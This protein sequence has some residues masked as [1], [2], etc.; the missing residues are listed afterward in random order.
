MTSKKKYLSDIFSDIPSVYKNIELIEAKVFKELGHLVVKVNGDNLNQKDLGEISSLFKIKFPSFNNVI[1]EIEKYTSSENLKTIKSMVEKHLNIDDLSYLVQKENGHYILKIYKSCDNKNLGALKSSLMD[2]SLDVHI[3]MTSCS[4]KN[5]DSFIEDIESADQAIAEKLS[6]N[7]IVE[8]KTSP[9]KKD[10]EN[11]TSE[12]FSY[13]KMPKKLPEKFLIKDLIPDSGKILVQGEIF[14]VDY[15]EIPAKALNIISIYFTDYSESTYTKVFIKD[16]DLNTYKSNLKEGSGISIVGEYTYDS[17]GKSDYIKASSFELFDIK[18][19]RDLANEKRIELHLH[20]SM[21]AQDGIDSP[22]E[23]IQR[24]SYW[25]HEAIA[26]TDHHNIQAFPEAMSSSKEFGIK[27]IYGLEVNLVDDT[28]DIIKNLSD[29]KYDSFVVFDVETTGFSSRNDKI[30]EIGAVKIENKKIVDSFNTL[31][32]P[33]RPISQEITDLTG[34]DDSMLIGQPKFEEICDEFANFI[35]GAILVAHNAAFDIGFLKTNLEKNGK[36]FDKAYI[37]TLEL[38]R[39]LYPNVRSHALGKIAK[40]LGISLENAHR[41]VDDARATA[42]VFM[43][44]T[45]D[46]LDENIE[47]SIT[48]IQAMKK[49]RPKYQGN[50][51]HAVLLAKNLV[52]LKN[53]YKIV[54]LS[55]MDYFYYTPRLPK[56]VLDE[57]RE[58]ILVSSACQDGEVFQNILMNEP[59]EKIKKTCSYYDYI[60]IQG[61]KNNKNLIPEY[62]NNKE[63]LENINKKIISFSDDLNIPVVATGDVHYLDEHSKKARKILSLATRSQRDEYDNDYYFMTTDEMLEEFAYLGDRAKEFVIDNP[64]LISDRI[65]E[66]S[67]IPSGSFPP[68]IEGSDDELVQTT[69]DQAHHIYGENLP[70]IIE[71]RIDKELDAII[72]NGYSVLYIIS[73]KLVEKSNQDGYQVGSRGSVG[74]SLVAYLCKITEVNPMPPHYV[75]PSCKNSIF[76]NSSETGVFSGVDLEEK[77]CPKCNTRMT[78]LGDEIPFEVFLGFDGDKEPDIDLNFASEYQSVAHAYTEELFGSDK[79]FRAGTIGTIAEKTAYG[80][81]QKYIEESIDVLSK[82]ETERL[83]SQLEGVK[84][85]TGQHAGGLIVVPDDKDIYDFTPIQYPANDNKSATITTHYDYHSIE[86]NLLKLDI[87]GHDVPSMIRMIEEMTGTDVMQVPLNDKDTL[88]IFSSSVVLKQDPQIFKSSVGTLGIPEFGTP[89]VMG[90]LEKTK[91]KSFSELV[92]ISGLSH[93]TNVWLSNAE[94]LVDSGKASL[95]DV[96]STREDIMNDLIAA[97]CENKFAFDTME[98]VRKGRGLSEDEEELISKLDLPAWYTDSLNKISYMFPKAHAVAYVTMSVR[99]AY[100]KVNYPAEFYAT[101]LSTKIS[102]FDC[103]TIIQGP[104]AIKE[105]IK[106]LKDSKENISKKE[107]DD[108]PIYQICLEAYSRGVSFKS[109]DLYKSHASTFTIED[110]KV[111]P[112]FRIAGSLGD[113]VAKNIVSERKK[114]KFLS[115]EDLMIRT[116]LTKTAAENLRSLGSFEGMSESNQLSFI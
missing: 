15:F 68:K 96:I 78:Q 19:R 86:E 93:G 91:P 40:R 25:G 88:S 92:Q 90:M 56:S 41:A 107:K 13:R 100:Y 10:Q 29:E 113:E 22:K 51:Y 5:K 116:K 95:P 73:K 12:E 11:P 32:N 54:S 9:I 75:C 53:L 69:M 30:I 36:K 8:S 77:Q 7:Q 26:I 87:L 98:K 44:F 76:T 106:T 23:M 6:K 2:A 34:I 48:N 79:V 28:V 27:V 99:L 33:S 38:S 20:T 114:A 57:H 80:Y 65:E 111:V 49:D 105:K 61:N 50:T 112:P 101:Y 102:N 103:E 108:I 35:D 85:T 39:I 72:S 89:F 3:D 55:H 47:K 71:E 59:D 16:E 18:T 37:D 60:E 62:F 58:G 74:S 42:E 109:V 115:V 14:K 45:K 4:F 94:D 64:K 70:K 46:I 97:G 17:Y 31:I 110:G 24:A 83:A 81:V 84:R 52:G 104:D 43:E 82:A 1:T 66:I 21:S 63:E 67:P